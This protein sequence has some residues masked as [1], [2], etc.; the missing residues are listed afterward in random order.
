MLQRSIE[1]R[2]GVVKLEAEE[3]P[4]VVLAD[5]GASR[6]RQR[7][8]GIVEVTVEGG[9][10]SVTVL[11]DGLGCLELARRVIEAA[12]VSATVPGVALPAALA[13]FEGADFSKPWDGAAGPAADEPDQG[14]VLRKL[15]A[16]VY[17]RMGWKPDFSD[18]ER[19]VD[20]LIARAK[21]MKGP[22]N[23][24]PAVEP[25]SN[26]GTVEPG[27]N[28]EVEP[29]APAAGEVGLPEVETEG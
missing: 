20:E 15:G 26:P 27:P 17:D 6:G 11:L 9:G 1:G 13:P 23:V 19:A 24:G 5:F 3:G 25:A 12:V 10:R 7:G 28:V 14:P 21:E 18:P 29:F 8:V 22:W 4:A 2:D 16:A